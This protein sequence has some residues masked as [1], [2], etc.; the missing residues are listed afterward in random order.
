M[1]FYT[2]R[3]I[4]RVIARSDEIQQTVK[5]G[6]SALSTYIQML[7]FIESDINKYFELGSGISAR[8]TM[9]R[10]LDFTTLNLKTLRKLDEEYKTLEV[11]DE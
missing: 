3:Q 4:A 9:R 11:K 6:Q 2:K 5:I 1:R 7:E 8:K 10:M